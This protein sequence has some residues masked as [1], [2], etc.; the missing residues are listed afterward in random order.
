MVLPGFI[1]THCH[2]IGAARDAVNNTYADLRSIAEVQEWIR[3]RTKVLA[4]GTWIEVPRNDITR[5]KE[6]RH[7]T[8]QELDA[9]TTEHPVI[10]TSVLKHVLNTAG[11]RAIGVVD[12]SSTIPDGEILHDAEGRP[13]LIRGGNVTVRQFMQ[14]P[15]VPKEKLMESLKK[16]HRIYN[17]V[18]ITSIFERATDRE[19]MM[20]FRELRDQDELTVRVTGTYRFSANTGEGVEK[21]I[22]KFGFKPG[23][24]DDWVK[25]G[26]LKITVDGG[27]H[28]GSTWLS[29]PHGAKRAAFYRN[30]DPD[31][32]G[33]RNYTPEQM[34]TVF[35][36]ANRL[37]WQM[38]THVTGD[39]GT[40]AVLDAVAAVAQDQPDIRQRRFTLIHAYFPSPAIVEKAKALGV[41]VDTQSYV[42][43]RDADILAEVY[44]QPW[45]DRFIGLGDWVR[46]GVPVAINSD[47]MIGLDPDHSM[48]SFNPFLML[49]IAVTRK[50]DSGA[51]HGAHQKLSRLDALRTVTQWAAWL[52]FDEDKLGTLEA[53]K[54]ADCVIIDRDY[55]TC[56][57]ED[58]RSIRG[59]KTLVGGTVVHEAGGGLEE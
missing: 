54:L 32:G 7:P 52:S 16:L 20:T 49:H 29:E 35:A 30:A 37:G 56:P 58:I 13:A 59:L 26:P 42:Y 24:G 34:R 25:A 1:E 39:G 36:T 6:H 33:Q 9:A 44:G 18:G 57:E 22:A 21:A 10:Y 51:V 45:A 8:P 2:S 5:L 38:S 28:W 31:Y 55:L 53:G 19:G 41:G 14:P 27:I 43:Q 50:T 23:E 17:S 4:P 15:V 12:G 48:N 40:E 46:A 3:G 47:H 11:F